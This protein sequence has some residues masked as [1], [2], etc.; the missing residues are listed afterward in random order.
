MWRIRAGRYSQ[1]WLKTL[2]EMSASKLK[3]RMRLFRM[4][5]FS[6]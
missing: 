6:A 2:H 1:A 5:L 4:L 3:A